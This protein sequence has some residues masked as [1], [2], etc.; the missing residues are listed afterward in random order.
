MPA[1][2]RSQAGHQSHL[3]VISVG[4]PCKNS[5][6]IIG[7]RNNDSPHHL[8]GSCNNNNPHR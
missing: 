6:S 5:R 8:V 3:L 1:R 4:D 2:L 7:S